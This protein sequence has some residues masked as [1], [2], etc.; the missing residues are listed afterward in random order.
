MPLA[1]LC[2]IRWRDMVRDGGGAW[3][4][5]GGGHGRNTQLLTIS[6]NPCWQ[7]ER[8]FSL[9]SLSC[10][11]AVSVHTACS[12]I[13]ELTGSVQDFSTKVRSLYVRAFVLPAAIRTPS[14]IIFCK[15]STTL[16]RFKPKCSAVSRLTSRGCCATDWR[17][18]SFISFV[19]FIS[20][21]KL[22]IAP[23]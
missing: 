9:R 21:N 16:R 10:G 15:W 5:M 1:G 6:V 19:L 17:I 14:S 8:R 3:S 23:K 11:E 2:P 22:L 7:I 13:D 12:S 20:P 4:E 18:N